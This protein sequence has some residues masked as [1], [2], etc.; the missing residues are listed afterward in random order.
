MH[1][2]ALLWSAIRHPLLLAKS[3]KYHYVK[4]MAS[5][6]YVVTLP[7]LVLIKVWRKWFDQYYIL[8]L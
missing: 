2:Y 6:M 4:I 1:N 7:Q 3:Y 8:W 5:V